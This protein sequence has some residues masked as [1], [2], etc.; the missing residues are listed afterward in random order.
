MLNLQIESH[1][2]PV[3]AAYATVLGETTIRK[4]EGIRLTWP[5]IDF[6]QRL[7]TVERSKNRKP[8]Y[9]PLSELALQTLASLPRLEG[10]PVCLCPLGERNALA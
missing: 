6:H 3:A 2:D 5:F 9:I 1:A 8:R 7:L 10:M 4:S